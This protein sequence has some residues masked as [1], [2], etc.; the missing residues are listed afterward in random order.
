MFRVPDSDWAGIHQ[1]AKLTPSDPGFHDSFGWAVD[2]YGND[3]T[4]V[5]GSH[6]HHNGADIGG[7]CVHAP[8]CCR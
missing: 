8:A 3:N 4:I 2:I 5:V 7:V 6:A 1:I